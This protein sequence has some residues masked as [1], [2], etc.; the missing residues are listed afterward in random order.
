M[1]QQTGSHFEWKFL[2]AVVYFL[3]IKLL[4]NSHVQNACQLGWGWERAGASLMGDLN[5][6]GLLNGTWNIDLSCWKVPSQPTARAGGHLLLSFCTN[7]VIIFVS[8]FIW[9]T[10]THPNTKKRREKHLSHFPIFKI[11]STLSWRLGGTKHDL[12]I[13]VSF[14]SSFTKA[15]GSWLCRCGRVSLPTLCLEHC[16]L[17]SMRLSCLFSVW[18]I[19]IGLLPFF[20]HLAREEI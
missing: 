19:Q 9:A 14:C 8:K 11:N 7:V 18:T 1:D 12:W 17:C 13:C 3:L 4:C 15:S 10:V 20:L 2:L 16:A 6:L 5:I